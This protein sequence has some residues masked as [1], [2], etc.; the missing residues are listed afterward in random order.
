MLDGV[1]NSINLVLI[2]QLSLAQ[3]WSFKVGEFEVVTGTS[4]ERSNALS[5]TFKT[6]IGRSYEVLEGTRFVN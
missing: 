6:F 4:M 5:N 3:N 2:V 1:S